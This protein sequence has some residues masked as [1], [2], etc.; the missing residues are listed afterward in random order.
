MRYNSIHLRST[1]E[2]I[3]SVCRAWPEG[4]G[5]ITVTVDARTKRRVNDSEEFE[6]LISVYF[7]AT[8]RAVQEIVGLMMRN[9]TPGVLWLS[10]DREIGQWRY[11]LHVS[12]DQTVRA[13]PT[14]RD[15]HWM[16]TGEQADCEDVTPDSFWMALKKDLLF[17]AF[18][19]PD[20]SKEPREVH[21][22]LPSLTS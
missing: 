17:D 13:L 1:E 15:P 21:D 6:C 14:E 3:D 7:S 9:L 2:V 5:N 4:A 19:S 16:D 8:S 12:E 22:D 11:T 20:G 18:V 10:L